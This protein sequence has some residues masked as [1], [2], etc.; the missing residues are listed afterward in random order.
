MPCSLESL[1]Y[2]LPA[3]Y[4]TISSRM[5]IIP[6]Y[7]TTPQPNMKYLTPQHISAFLSSLF[8]KQG[9]SGL[10]CVT[11][12]RQEKGSLSDWI[13]LPCLV[14]KGHDIPLPG[15]EQIR[16]LN[17]ECSERNST[18]QISLLCFGGKHPYVKSTNRAKRNE[19]Q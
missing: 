14:T 19:S 16:N 15:T 10:S 9:R 8:F 12:G 6:S 17:Y 11:Q 13:T 4:I 7:S 2:Q 5:L 3:V 18:I 1:G